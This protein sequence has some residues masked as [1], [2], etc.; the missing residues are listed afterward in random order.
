[1]SSPSPTYARGRAVSAVLELFGWVVFALGVVTLVGGLWSL[2]TPPAA[3]ATAGPLGAFIVV[4]F[5]ILIAAAGLLSV[6]SALT[7]RATFHAARDTHLLLRRDPRPAAGP[8]LPTGLRAEPKLT[9]PT[10]PR[11]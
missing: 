3:L 9:R 2:L 7:A 5:G 8:A 1:M 10:A 11:A 4:S 6:Q